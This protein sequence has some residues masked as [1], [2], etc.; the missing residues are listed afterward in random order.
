MLAKLIK[1]K[2]DEYLFLSLFGG[3]E[4]NV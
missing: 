3:Y 1:P 4:I 2:T